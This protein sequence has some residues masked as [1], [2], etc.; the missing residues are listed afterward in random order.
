MAI[1]D[2]MDEDCWR[3]VLWAAKKGRETVSLLLR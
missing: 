2:C 3:P 1:I